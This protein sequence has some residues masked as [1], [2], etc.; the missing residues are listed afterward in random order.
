[1]NVNLGPYAK[2]IVAVLAACGVLA[3]VIAD[4]HLSTEDAVA[5]GSAFV[6]A[7]F[8]RQVKNQPK[9]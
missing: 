6:G 5:V 2:F 1:M 3:A 9:A 8:V 4:G 7:G